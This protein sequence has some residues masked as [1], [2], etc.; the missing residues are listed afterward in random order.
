[1]PTQAQVLHLIHSAAPAVAEVPEAEM[2]A[3]RDA[4][5][6]MF[7][8][9]DMAELQFLRQLSS[10]LELQC[11]HLAEENARLKEENEAARR[12]IA[13]TLSGGAVRV[14]VAR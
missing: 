6:A 7:S 12:L 4:L 2:Q 3:L 1:M 14:G 8:A 13:I 10:A 11:K 9:A 5:D